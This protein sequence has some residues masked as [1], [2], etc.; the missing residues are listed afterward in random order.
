MKAKFFL[1]ALP[2]ALGLST[3][4]ADASMYPPSYPTCG[5]VDTVSTG[6][7]EIIRNSVDLYDAHALLTIA[8]RGYLRDM[9]P[10]DE[11]NIYVQLN[12]ND[13]FLPA[14][15]GT[16][17]DAYVVLDSGPRNC[18]WCSNGG[19][20]GYSVCD[21]LTFPPYSSGQWVC[22]DMSPTEEHL[23]YWAFNEYGAQNA[24][25]IQVAAESHGNWDSNWG[26]NYYGRLEPRLHCS[27]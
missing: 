11:I 12:D 20:G 22:G 15:A 27:D 7:F 4:E 16:N 10:D 5:I 18:V 13:A 23:F 25:D 2:L 14:S 19:Y 6:P 3:R 1:L 8:Y 9:Y 17:D 21:G 26:F 24:W